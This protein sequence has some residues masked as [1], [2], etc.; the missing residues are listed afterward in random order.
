[1]R[2]SILFAII[3]VALVAALALSAQSASAA[4][5][6]QVTNVCVT[7]QTLYVTVSAV[8]TIQ[9]TPTGDQI[10]VSA[11]SLPT[12]WTSIPADHQT[13]SIVASFLLAAYQLQSPIL[14]QAGNGDG[15]QNPSGAPFAGSRYYVATPCVVFAGSGAPA[16]FVLHTITCTVPVFNTPAGNPVGS[17]VIL[18]GQ[19]WFVNPTPVMDRFGRFWT[20]I[21]VAGPVDAFIPTPC[22][23]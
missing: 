2:R 19:T 21:F 13:H 15:N 4:S 1:M 7:G 17:N 22:V 18:G 12:F 5:N 23:H 11:D 8:G 16:G 6:G 10:G 14:V 20:E 3:S 9:D